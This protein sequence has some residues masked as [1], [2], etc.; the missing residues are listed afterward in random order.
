MSRQSVVIIG[1]G[2]G[3]LFTG[4]ILAREGFDVTV[5][6]KN[7]T[8]GGGLQSFS[9]FGLSFDTGMHVVG[10][11]SSEGNVRKICRYLGI[12]EQLHVLDVDDDCTDLLYFAED[13]TY[14]RTAKG[15]QN[16][17]D[18]LSAYFPAERQGLEHY[19]EAVFDMA[20]KVDLFNLR[21]SSGQITLF[22]TEGDF[23]LSADAF[24]AR[25]VSDRRLRSVL[26]YMN[27]LYGGRAGQTPAY[28]HAIISVLYINGAVRFVGDSLH[29]AYLLA[30]V[31]TQA[32]GSV[33][34]GD[35]VE[36]IITTNRHVEG[37]RTQSGRI[38]HADY[39]I[40]AIHPCTM[41]DLLDPGA[42]P[43][44][45]RHRLD[46]IPNAHSAFTMSIRLKEGVFPYINHSEYFMTRY[47]DVWNFSR[48]DRPWPLGFLFM[49]P[50]ETDQGPYACKAIITAPMPFS[51]VAPWVQTQVPGQRGDD[52][53]QWKQARAAEIMALVEQMHPGFQDMV[54]Q[55]NTASPLTIRDFY[56]VKEGSISGFSKDCRNIVLSQLP[57]ATKL[58][59]LLLTGQ[60]VNL[61]G[62]CGVS[63]TAITTAE[64]I[65][66]RNY[67][68]NK[69]NE[70]CNERKSEKPA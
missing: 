30:G 24:I 25:Y 58:D 69:I 36:H 59:N 48:D 43:K 19:V 26:A 47:D 44:A 1:A 6:E 41:L 38:Y 61:H 15:K 4:A 66:G 70:C 45:Y 5:L 23:L 63:L 14:Y 34:C 28:V 64:A 18:S 46:S 7:A 68:I 67:V 65:L 2:L 51:M 32:G 10:G 16:F 31:I 29:A 39:Y 22:A 56:G 40:S 50:P 27:P 52:Y 37:V 60:N 57:V 17:V 55:V 53:E 35:G 33:V 11:L 8:M 42:L 3:G 54:E 12:E 49:T 20:G 13:K 21:P 62:F 9:R